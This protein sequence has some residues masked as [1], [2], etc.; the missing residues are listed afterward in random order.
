M[1]RVSDTVGG[2]CFCE[3]FIPKLGS[4]SLSCKFLSDT[5]VINSC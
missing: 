1:I 2:A 4:M 3:T 5:L